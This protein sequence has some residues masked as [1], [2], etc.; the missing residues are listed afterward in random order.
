MLEL[1]TEEGV[2]VNISS[3]ARHGSFGQSNYSAAKSAVA[4]MAEVWAEELA[5][6]NIRTGAVAGRHQHRHAGRHEAGSPRASGAG[7][8]AA[9]PG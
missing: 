8:A 3:L 2:I 6:Y 4:A 7:G 9:S 5:R 1:G